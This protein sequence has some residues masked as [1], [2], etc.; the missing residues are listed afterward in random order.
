MLWLKREA[1][2]K[3]LLEKL[4]RKETCRGPGCTWLETPVPQYKGL[5]TSDSRAGS[6]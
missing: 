2:L 3:I 1:L 5:D 6:D 4:Q